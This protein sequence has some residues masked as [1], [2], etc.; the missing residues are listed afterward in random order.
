MKRTHMSYA[1]VPVLV[2]ILA[3]LF[4]PGGASAAVSQVI[5]TGTME[6]AEQFGGPATILMRRLTIAPG[7]VLGWHAHPGVG[8]YTVVKRG[9][10]VIEDGCGGET[11]YAAGQAFLEP[12]NRVHRGKNLGTEE[13]ETVQMFLVRAGTSISISTSQ[14]C[15]APATV[16]E[17]KNDGW[18][19][20]TY[21]RAFTSQG[22]CVQ[23][24]MAG[25]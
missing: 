13:V 21:P 23:S 8:A 3:A 6:H 25:K 19:T 2:L 11:T 10:L 9:T 24:M 18:T 14:V 22:D 20:F 1:S 5:A 12:A 4:V 16:N 15:G 7:E 17:C